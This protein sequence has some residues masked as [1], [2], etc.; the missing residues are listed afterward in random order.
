MP[1]QT[2]FPISDY[3]ELEPL[4]EKG[5]VVLVRNLQDGQLYVKKHIQSFTPNIYRQLLED[6]VENTPRIYGIWED[7]DTPPAPGARPLI[8]IEEYLPGHTLLERLRDEGPFSE[9]V[10]IQIGM[11][12]CRILTRLHSRKNPIIHR[13]IKPSNVM[14]L[15]DGSLRLID[16]SAAK[17]VSGPENRDTVLIG[18]AG[19]AAPE[20][21]GFSASTPQ[22]DLYALGVL[23]NILLTGALPW[24]QQAEGRLR[25]IIS[26]CLKMDPKHRYAGAWELHGALK[27]AKQQRI[28]WLPPGFRSLRW[29]TMIPALLWYVFVFIF[30]F[31]ADV[32]AETDPFV[33]FYTRMTFLLMGLL[34]TFFYGNYLDIRRLFPLMRSRSRPLRLLGLV[35]APVFMVL[36]ILL[37]AVMVAVFSL[38]LPGW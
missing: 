18:T 4:C 23:L 7:P 12:L 19:F 16:F 5:H 30:A 14:L 38:L 22:T 11:D 24:E 21:Y 25:G 13:D 15:P 32:S 26:R 34:P 31:R 3:Q 6:P 29:Y 2:A 37:L 35:L 10:C 9:K 28:P 27:K 36:L 33:R 1:Q 8:L 17:A 20:Q